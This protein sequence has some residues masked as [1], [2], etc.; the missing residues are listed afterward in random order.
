MSISLS[1]V[2]IPNTGKVF[3]LSLITFTVEK[4]ADVSRC[5][6][7]KVFL[8]ISQNSPVP[9]FLFNRVAGLRPATLLKKRFWYRSFPV[10]FAKFLK[11][12]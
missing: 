1:S 4:K 7:E 12:L 2:N 10:N 11:G 6:A 3:Y 8:E 5:S 9:E